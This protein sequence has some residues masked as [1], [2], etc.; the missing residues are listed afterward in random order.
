[1]S[2][3]KEGIPLTEIGEAKGDDGFTDLDKLAAIYYKPDFAHIEFSLDG[4]SSVLADGGAMIWMDAGVEMNTQ[5]GGCCAS[6][7][8]SNCAGESCCQNTYSGTGKISF[9][10][11]YPGDIQRFGISAESS[12][13]VTGGSFICGTTNC[14]VSAQFIGCQACCCLSAKPFLTKVSMKEG[15]GETGSFFSGGYGAIVEKNIP[16]GETLTV[17]AGLFFGTSSKN[18]ISVTCPGAMECMFSKEIC[19]QGL[20]MQFRGPCKVYLQN[21][22]PTI[23]QY[24]LNR[25]KPKKKKGANYAAM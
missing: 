19:C 23:W 9:G 10:F 14:V 3:F 7:W 2:F 13:V 11:V 8:R 24:V 12:W 22:D 17:S 21:R 25:P 5:M 15:E 4:T 20:Y 16:E 18:P 6:Y 1:M